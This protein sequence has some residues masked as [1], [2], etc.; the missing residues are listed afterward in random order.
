MRTT[1]VL[2]ATLLAA[3]STGC[4]RRTARR[5]AALGPVALTVPPAP[6]PTVVAWDG[7]AT[8]PGAAAGLVELGVGIASVVV[9]TKVERSLQAAVQPDELAA[10]LEAGLWRGLASED[11]PFTVAQTGDNTLS[12]EILEHGIDVTEGA[13]LLFVQVKTTLHDAGG[14]RIY[15]G[16]ERCEARVGPGEDVPLTGIDELVALQ[17]ARKTSPARMA[18]RLRMLGERCGTAVAAKLERDL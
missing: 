1:V 8:A 9:G 13:P 6:A 5:A 15:R 10:G 12:V 7:E 2:A 14:R 11:L 18:D 17:R 3:P 4:H 16:W